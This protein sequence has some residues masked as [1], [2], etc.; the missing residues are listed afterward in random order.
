M[1]QI[2]ATQEWVRA[3]LQKAALYHTTFSSPSGR[4]VLIDLAKECGAARTTYDKDAR[5]QARLEGRRQVWLHISKMLKLTE[6]DLH[7]LITEGKDY[8]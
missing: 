4:R 5:E 6:A 1:R 7:Q 3:Q 8:E 2:R